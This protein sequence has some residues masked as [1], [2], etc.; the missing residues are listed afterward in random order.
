L[1][2]YSR[3]T[4]TNFFKSADSV[5]WNGLTIYARGIAK[6]QS[7]SLDP[8]NPKELKA[9]GP[10]LVFGNKDAGYNTIFWSASPQASLW[11]NSAYEMELGDGKMNSIFGST[12]YPWAGML[13]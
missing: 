3:C 13:T 7:G 9:K 5:A 11:L 8:V 4:R 12:P 10:F 6:Y 2:E 1:G